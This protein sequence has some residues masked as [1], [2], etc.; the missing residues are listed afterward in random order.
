[1]DLRKVL[2]T[3]IHFIPQ[4]AIITILFI[5]SYLFVVENRGKV[6]AKLILF[7]KKKWLALFIIY[8]SCLLTVTLI[9]RYRTNPYKNMIG[10]FGVCADG[11]FNEEVVANIILYIPYIFCFIKAWEPKHVIRSSLLL[12]VGTTVCI[13]LLQLLFWLGQFSIADIIH[14]TIG[15]FI[16][17]GIWYIGCIIKELFRL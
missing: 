1:M 3:I 4:T 11:K 14:N 16:G 10:S 5:M 12:T 9:G 17:C 15:G 8:T 13:E 7:F 6:K 2:S